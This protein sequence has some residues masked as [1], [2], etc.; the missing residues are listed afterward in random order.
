M[1]FKIIPAAF[2][3]LLP[4]GKTDGIGGFRLYPDDLSDLHSAGAVQDFGNVF[5][6]FVAPNYGAKKKDRINR[7]IRSAGLCVLIFCSVISLLVCTFAKPLMTL[8]IEPSETEIIASGV[9]YLPIEGAC[10]LDH[11]QQ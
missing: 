8:F 5:S 9:H 7:G 10:C 3:N 4:H 2:S 1:I 6:T 11:K